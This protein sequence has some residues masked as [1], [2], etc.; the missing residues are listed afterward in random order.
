MGMNS[1]KSGDHLDL[2]MIA[3][4]IH[5][6]M[7]SAMTLCNSI[8]DALRHRLSV[9]WGCMLLPFLLR[10]SLI[11]QAGSDVPP[12]ASAGNTSSRCFSEPPD[13]EAAS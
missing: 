7:N 8:G 9:G 1:V 3:D 6:A 5:S 12:A 11:Y 4:R 2:L 13:R 10:N